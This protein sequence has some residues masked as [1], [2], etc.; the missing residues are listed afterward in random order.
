MKTYNEMAERVFARMEEYETAKKRRRKLYGKLSITA[1]CMALVMAI[2]ATPLLKNSIPKTED[3]GVTEKDESICNGA[4]VPEDDGKDGD[5]SAHDDAI[6]YWPE[7]EKAMSESSSAENAN[8]GNLWYIGEGESMPE[9]DW[10]TI[11]DSY[12]GGDEA[13]YKT[14][15]NGAFFYSIPLNAAIQEYGD[16]AV[17]YRVVLAVFHDGEAVT[18]PAALKEEFGRISDLG[19]EA[20]FETHKNGNEKQYRLGVFASAH[21]L[22]NFTPNPE[23]GYTFFLYKERI[24]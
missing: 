17:A 10:A 15:D 11:I 20:F 3:G 19:Y 7:D 6:S 2:G 22:A 12:P 1:C 21:D 5:W 18:D 23:Y 24:A 9:I 14:P 16:D 13:C 8:G 4:V